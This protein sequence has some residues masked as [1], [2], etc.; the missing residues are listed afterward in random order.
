MAQISIQASHQ[1]TISSISAASLLLQ[2]LQV[3]LIVSQEVFVAGLVLQSLLWKSFLVVGDGTFRL[4]ILYCQESQL[5]TPLSFLE[6]FIV[7]GS[8]LVPTI[9]VLFQYSLPPSY[10]H[11]ILPISLCHVILFSIYPRCLFYFSFSMTFKHPPL[12][13]SCQLASLG[14]WIVEWLSCTL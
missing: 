13:P 9:P 2:V 14:L 7:L 10:P 8:Q 5:A 12:G 11:F 6:V 4:H 3:E 1:L